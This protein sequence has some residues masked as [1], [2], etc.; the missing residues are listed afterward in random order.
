MV[1]E[2]LFALFSQ[3]GIAGLPLASFILS[4]VFFPGIAEALIVLYIPLKFNPF[5]VFL[6]VTLGSIAGGLVNYY[7]GVL[8]KKIAFKKETLDKAHVWLKKWGNLSVFITSFIPGFP[9]DIIAVL[10]GFLGLD[11]RTF[12][13]WMSLGKILK[14]GLVTLLVVFG[15]RAIHKIAEI[16]GF[17]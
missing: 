1:A 16:F 7:F 12:F 9:F 15:L 4:L 6:L 11:F 14:F 5:L 17:L 8:G 13:I 10:V 3:Y 2:A